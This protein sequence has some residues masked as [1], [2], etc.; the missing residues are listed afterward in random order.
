MYSVYILYSKN[1]DKFYIGFT[2][3]LKRRLAEHKAKKNHTTSRYDNFELV[4]SENFKNKQDALRREK[5]FK[6]TKGRKSL[7]L[8]LKEML[9]ES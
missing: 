7:R 3:D 8:M 5:Y 1:D 6:T 4:L 9:K 2:S